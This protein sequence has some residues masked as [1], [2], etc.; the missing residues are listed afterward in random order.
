MAKYQARVCPKCKFYLGFSII[1]AR[2]RTT[3]H[4]VVGSCLN[5]DYTIPVHKIIVGK[6]RK[7]PPSEVR[8]RRLIGLPGNAKTD[9]RTAPR[10][11]SRSRQA[12]AFGPWGSY[13]QSLRAI[14]QHLENSHVK[15]FNL[16]CS[17]ELYSVW[18]GAEVSSSKKSPS[19]VFRR[20]LF[21]TGGQNKN[22]AATSYKYSPCDIDRIER[23]GKSRREQSNGMPDGHSRSQ[24]L[25]TIGGLVNK[26]GNRLLGI[27]WQN[28]CVA[29]VVEMSSGR[30]E[31]DV[32]RPEHLYDLW[33]KMYLSRGSRALSELPQ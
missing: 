30:R 19:S 13:S 25:R 22:D 11:E 10:F 2:F 23:D 24:L 5:C 3:E 28:H 12:E 8:F 20:G 4:S 33:V 21:G 31:I 17:E 14:G 32:F 16:Q 29:I 9:D 7:V 18:A 27:S 1:R 15:T 6:K 26:R